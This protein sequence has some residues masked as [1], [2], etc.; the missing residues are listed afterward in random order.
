MS[1]TSQ[2]DLACMKRWIKA[3][4]KDQLTKRLQGAV[5]FVE[6]EDRLTSKEPRHYELRIDGPYLRPSG[7][8]REF[9]VYVEVNILASSTRDESNVYD[10]ENLQGQMLFALTNDFCIYRTGNVGK[11]AED[12][13]SLV[14]VMQLITHDRIKVSDFGMIDTNTELYQ[15]VAEAHYEMYFTVERQ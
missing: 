13:E 15:S 7:S 4:L 10:R 2:P 14:G 1:L 12:D 11:V 9:C 3:S 6:G 8:S 5:S